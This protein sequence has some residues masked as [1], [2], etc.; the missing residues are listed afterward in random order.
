MPVP[1][2][3]LQMRRG[4]GN[5]PLQQQKT[6]LEA[7]LQGEKKETA[8]L[9]SAA[10]KGR[11][12]RQKASR[13]E[14]E[15][16]RQLRKLLLRRIWLAQSKAASLEASASASAASAAAAERQPGIGGMRR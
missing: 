7:Q 4:R 12:E 9:K 13:L 11:E 5:K 16:P 14:G 8:A 15:Y 1:P 3:R 10:A 6:Q 2:Y